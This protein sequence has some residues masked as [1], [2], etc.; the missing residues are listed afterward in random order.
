[1]A[2]EIIKKRRTYEMEEIFANVSDKRLLSKIYK[3]FIKF[4]NKK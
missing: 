2:K 3:K 4:N 1:M